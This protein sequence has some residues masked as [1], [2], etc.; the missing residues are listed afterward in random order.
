MDLSQSDLKK[1]EREQ[2]EN[3]LLSYSDAFP[4]NKARS[5]DVFAMDKHHILYS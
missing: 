2:L 4:K 1:H 5:R 3:F